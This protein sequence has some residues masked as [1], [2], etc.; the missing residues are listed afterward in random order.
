MWIILAYINVY[1]ETI[2]L[3][4]YIVF[5]DLTFFHGMYIQIESNME[6]L[7]AWIEWATLQIWNEQTLGYPFYLCTFTLN[8]LEKNLV[9][10]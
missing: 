4:L 10:R 5:Q 7:F 6:L 9:A 3:T 1:M 8:A 2:I